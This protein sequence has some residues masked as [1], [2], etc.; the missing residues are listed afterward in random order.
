MKTKIAIIDFQLGNLFSVIQACN[1]FGYEPVIT[2]DPVEVA[3]ADALILPGV[4]AFAEAMKNLNGN[5][6]TDAIVEAVKKGKPLMGICL[7]M[8]LL[9][10]GSE[11]FS[12]EKGIGLLPGKIRKIP[13]ENRR[14][15]PQ[16]GWNK[17]EPYSGEWDKTP[18][19][20]LQKGDFMYFVHS[21]YCEPAVE[22]DKL[23]LTEYDGFNYCS[24][25]MRD[26]VFATQFHPEKSGPK[27]LSIYKNWLENIC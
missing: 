14:K 15:I 5:G 21:Y 10:E 6:L 13:A 17:I 18:L 7:G 9:F 20:S 1:Y 23:S 25:V 24:A 16:I 19:R 2:S 11:E 12:T 4:G 8:Q 26:N 27:G 3:Q 22:K